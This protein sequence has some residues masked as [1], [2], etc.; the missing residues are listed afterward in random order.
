MVA[1]KV[2]MTDRCLRRIM[3]FLSCVALSYITGW[4]WGYALAMTVLFIG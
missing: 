2:L 1:G 3:M 4:E